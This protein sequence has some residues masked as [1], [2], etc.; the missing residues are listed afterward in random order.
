ME[1]FVLPHVLVLLLF[2]VFW[3]TERP[4]QRIEKAHLTWG[5]RNVVWGASCFVCAVLQSMV[6][7]DA[8]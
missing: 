1:L 6:R 2:R 8:C 4:Q 3:E 5:N 7:S